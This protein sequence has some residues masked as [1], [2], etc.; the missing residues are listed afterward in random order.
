M[1]RRVHLI[2]GGLMLV[3][4]YVFLGILL[5]ETVRLVLVSGHPA[6]L[7]IE[8][9]DAVFVSV[10]RPGSPADGVLRIGDEVVAVNGQGVAQGFE[11]RA[12]FAYR[13]PGPY[14]LLIRREGQL[15]E[16][17][18]ETV[19]YGLSYATF[20]ALGFPAVQALFLLAG[21]IVFVLRPLETAPRLL[22]VCFVLFSLGSNPLFP[23]ETLPAWQAKLVVLGQSV[24]AFF[25]PVFLHLFL[26]FPEPSPLLR[27][28]PG[29]THWAYLP[30]LT[31][32]IA[33]ALGADLT[34][35]NP[36]AGAAFFAEGSLFTSLLQS[37]IVLYSVAGLVSLVLSYH[38][39]KPASRRR[40]RLLVAGSLAGFLPLLVLMVVSLVSD[41]FVLGLWP[42]RV[43][44]L[45]TILSLPLVPLSFA[46]AIVKH[47]VVPLGVL[48]RR[49][50][51]YLLVARGFLI[52]EVLEVALVL[53]FLLGGPPAGWLE[54]LPLAS[55]V[56]VT[57]TVIGLSL[58]ALVAAHR[59]VMPRIDR[60][61]FRGS[62]DTQRILADIGNVAR[63]ARG[64][65]EVL[66]LGLDRVTEA[67]H[68]ESAGVFLR[69]ETTGHYVLATG[70]EKGSAALRADSAV[71]QRL[72]RS[73]APIDAERDGI[74]LPIVTKGDLLGIL[75]LGPRLG[76]LPY[77]RED[78]ALLNA[79]GW[80]MAYAV[81]NA[82]LVR[83]MVDEARLRRE[84]ELAG[85]VQR[86][87]F[88]ERP[89]ET[90]RLELAGLCHP[91]QGIGG[92]YYDFLTTGD[93]RVGIAVADVAGKGISAA[94]LMSIVQ[95]SLRSQYGGVPLPELVASMNR[96]L[97][98]STARNAFASFFVA[99]F[100]EL[101]GRL[102]YVNAGHNPPLLVRPNGKAASVRLLQTGGLVIGALADVAYEVEAVE[103]LP[104]DLI[105]AYTDGVTEA[106]DPDEQEFGE[107]RLREV[108]LAAAHLPVGVVAD[109]IVEAVH[110]FVREAPQHDDITL[111][112]AR[113]RGAEPSA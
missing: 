99:Q 69:D 43:L 22:A 79:V 42:A 49:S 86:R 21:T 67:V 46:Y 18:L 85:D 16:L 25:W 62:Y 30:A 77:D 53:A 58:L 12:Y 108:V 83:R 104:G 50:L 19:P 105:V 35:E 82:R 48:V 63:E 3:L 112:V 41:L 10:I 96:L 109:R 55:A 14:R 54:S 80:Q 100:D 59:A 13:A 111:V 81:E 31:I 68:P 76:D 57:L 56:L 73:P 101:S 51:R 44:L 97:Y 2:A 29:L 26:V 39:A 91:A 64:V 95:A 5:R 88:P 1:T 89:P 4:G 65:E 36:A 24:G 52:L 78:R 40:L 92:D 60:R 93:G 15:Q 87:L 34:Q 28:W 66:Q 23:F 94:L 75:S 106:F 32:P 110:L 74:L 6:W 20:F 8:R 70:E 33:L 90:R 61:F 11:A 113:V 47:Q 7:A 102:A 98:R 38:E 37:L 9:D 103:L 84:I 107:D 45:W 27:R 17:R 71:V 72:R